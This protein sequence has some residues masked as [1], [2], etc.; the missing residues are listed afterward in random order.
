[1][2]VVYVLASLLQMFYHGNDDCHMYVANNIVPI[3]HGHLILLFSTVFR[4][5][6]KL[7]EK[8]MFIDLLEVILGAASSQED[9]HI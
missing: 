9:K 5:I 4:E 3:Y 6:S 7:K 2:L 1:M 8:P